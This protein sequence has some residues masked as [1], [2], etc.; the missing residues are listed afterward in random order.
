MSTQQPEHPSEWTL[1]RLHA[2]ELSTAEATRARTHAAECE[3]CGAVLRDAEG[4]QRQFEA[5]IPFERFEAGVNRAVEKAEKQQKS[6]RAAVV[7]WAGP[8]VAIAA[9][10]LVVVAARPLLDSGTVPGVRTKG[11]ATAELR[12]GGGEGPQR[13]AQVDAPETLNRGERVRLGYTPAERKY[14]LA[15]SVDASGEVTP[16]YPETG[17]SLPVE[18]G[19]GPHW[20]PGSLEFTGLGAER[21]VVLLSDTPVTVAQASEAARWSFAASGNS[22]ATMDPLEVDGDQTHW[23]LLKL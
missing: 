1:R 8:V 2:G 13:V 12:I 11:G 19:A 7:R 16:L 14:V 4:A 17:Q 18:P 9:A 5:D 6:S 22:V 3:Q 23:V 20:L 21:V 15:L 10:V